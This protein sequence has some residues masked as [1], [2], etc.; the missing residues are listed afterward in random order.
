MGYAICFFVVNPLEDSATVF[1]CRVKFF[2]QIAA[3]HE[4]WN[5]LSFLKVVFLEPL[6]YVFLK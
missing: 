4:K 2:F 6:Y 3:F 5:I 1:R